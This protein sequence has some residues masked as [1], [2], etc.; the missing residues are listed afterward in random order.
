MKVFYF[1]LILISILLSC[2]NFSIRNKLDTRTEENMK[3]TAF[4]IAKNY[5]VSFTPYKKSQ[6]AFVSREKESNG[7]IN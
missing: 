1:I 3:L 2:R 7:I 6:V 5:L 4:T